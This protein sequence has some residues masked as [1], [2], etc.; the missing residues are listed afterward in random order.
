MTGYGSLD[1]L[2]KNGVIFKGLCIAFGKMFDIDGRYLGSE[3]G[4]CLVYRHCGQHRDTNNRSTLG[5]KIS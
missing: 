1:L 4:G 5:D 3:V 2:T